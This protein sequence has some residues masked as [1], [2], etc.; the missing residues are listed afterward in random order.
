MQIINGKYGFSE[1]QID[2]KFEFNKNENNNIDCYFLL[3][4]NNGE[5]LV[6]IMQDLKQIT[7]NYVHNDIILATDKLKIHPYQSAQKYLKPEKFTKLTKEFFKQNTNQPLTDYIN[8]YFHSNDNASTNSSNIEILDLI[9]NELIPFLGTDDKNLT[10]NDILSK[11]IKLTKETPYPWNKN[12]ISSMSQDDFET[13]QKKYLELI[14]PLKNNN[15]IGYFFVKKSPL[16]A[17]L[18]KFLNKSIK[19][20]QYI[21]AR[22][23]EINFNDRKIGIKLGENKSSIFNNTKYYVNNDNICINT[24]QYNKIQQQIQ[25]MK[26]KK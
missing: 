18:D 25:E 11:P 6:K 14:K 19:G 10:Y 4:A 16:K 9:F 7:Y 12:T 20:D 8:M 3:D 1:N 22:I 15:I 17:V 2:N 5:K 24:E 23:V 13:L 21:L 26:T